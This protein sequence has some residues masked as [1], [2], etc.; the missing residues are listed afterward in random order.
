[1]GNQKPYGSRNL[2]MLLAGLFFLSITVFTSQ[3]CTNHFS[4]ENG[5]P[6]SSTITGNNEMPNENNN[7]VE[8]ENSD[9][10]PI[11]Q[12]ADLCQAPGVQWCAGFDTEKEVLDFANAGQGPNATKPIQDHEIKYSGSGSLKFELRGSSGANAAGEWR[13]SLGKDFAEN[14]RFYLTYK[15]RYSPEALSGAITNSGSGMKQHILSHHTA[16]CNN[17]EI[18]MVHTFGRGYPSMYSRCGSD[19]FRLYHPPYGGADSWEQWSPNYTGATGEITDSNGWNKMTGETVGPIKCHYNPAGYFEP[20]CKKFRANS[21][22]TFYFEV[23]IGTW[24]A[25]NSSVKAW[26]AHEGEE[27]QPFI[28]LKHHIFKTG[29][30]A[31]SYDTLTLHTYMSFKKSDVPHPTAYAWYDEVIVSADPIFSNP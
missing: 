16:T 29:G 8:E 4:P 25:P 20:E 2:V 19:P 12:F 5:E 30:N 9:P 15:L 23:K 27:L 21:W 26:M 13:R 6:S 11:G 24:G 3:N 22:M 17:V 1:M 7:P 14:S 31:I 18:T 10:L 28:D